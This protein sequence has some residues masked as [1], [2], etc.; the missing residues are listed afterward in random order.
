MI[1]SERLKTS[2]TFGWL[3]FSKVVQPVEGV[4]RLL[5][6]VSEQTVPVVQ[7]QDSAARSF[8]RT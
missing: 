7:L 5:Q 3:D 2:L 8:P 4:S 6:E 1:I